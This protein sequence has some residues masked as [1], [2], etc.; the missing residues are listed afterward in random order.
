MHLHLYRNFF[1]SCNLVVGVH[2]FKDEQVTLHLIFL[3]SYQ[4]SWL[5]ETHLYRS[6][7]RL[8]YGI[9]FFSINLTFL[10]RINH[11]WRVLIDQSD[12]SDTINKKSSFHLDNDGHKF[13]LFLHCLF[14]VS[15]FSLISIFMLEPISTLHDH[16]YSNV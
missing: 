10:L 13:I 4:L 11:R 3:H 7:N 8:V 6:F 14:L 16:I 2:P 5:N 9:G 1:R 12:I 15:V